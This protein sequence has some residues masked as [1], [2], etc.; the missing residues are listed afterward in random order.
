MFCPA[1]FAV[2]MP[3]C[4]TPV[5]QPTSPG[6]GVH[7]SELWERPGNV[8][9][10]DLY[11]G[12]W[13]REHAPDPSAVYTF[14]RPKTTGTNPGMTVRDAEGR[15]WHVKQGD[16]TRGAE[17]PAEVALSR[18]LDAVGYHQP[19]IFYLSAFTL[20][21]HGYTHRE[22]GGRFRLD[23]AS[24]KNLAEWSW[25]QN[26]FVGTKP[27]QG[28]LVILL[29]FNSSDLKNANNSLYRYRAADG[30]DHRWFVVRD[31][32]TALGETGRVA[33][34]RA[35]PGLFERSRFI[36]G[37]EHGFVRFDYHG[38]HQEL[39]R[40]RITPADVGW[41][42]DLLSGLTITQWQDAFRAGGYEAPVGERF[43]REIRARIERGRQLAAAAG[44]S[45]ARLR[46]RS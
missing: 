27:Y 42:S 44:G 29:M 3:S 13:G 21:G 5:V 18:V 14:V 39:V 16:R 36:E 20:T 34:R 10:R 24:L 46:D 38:F 19:P 25:Q 45:R 12:R 28:L 1:L 32:G 2:Y 35:D 4:H 26:P 43:I 17:G 9:D 40:E 41:A 37:V 23:T 7:M 11:Y 6:A 33:P 30:T 22:P 31:L 8:A 15:Q